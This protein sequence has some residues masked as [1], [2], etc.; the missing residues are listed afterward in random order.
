MPVNIKS[1]SIV[2]KGSP[3]AREAIACIY[4]IRKHH[5]NIPILCL[6]DTEARSAL[7]NVDCEILDFDENG[8]SNFNIPHEKKQHFCPISIYGKMFIMKKAIK[9][10]GNTMFVDADIIL[11]NKI[12]VEDVELQLSQHFHRDQEK[13]RLYGKYNAG[14]VF[15][16][17]EKVPELWADLYLQ[18]QGFYEQSPLEK[19]KNS[20]SHAKFTEDH[21][22]GF[23]RKRMPHKRKITSLHFHHRKEAYA[24]ADEYLKEVYDYF[25]EAFMHFVPGDIK[26]IMHDKT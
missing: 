20:F 22:V 1:F 2:A 17:N 10:H 3:H 7:E 5:G 9:H 14:Y 6:A 19:L 24:D 4:T 8:F 23:W 16:Q 11:L 21:N 25:R 15:A 18:G 12:E 26:A 13:D